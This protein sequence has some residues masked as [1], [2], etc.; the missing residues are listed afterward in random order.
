M[1][2]TD[3]TIGT[4]N[5]S[6]PDT[7]EGVKIERSAARRQT[8][9]GRGRD[10]GILGVLVVL[11]ITL[12]LTTT[13]FM[14][15]RNMTNV[16]EA[17]VVLGILA[18]SGGIVIIAGGLDLSAGAIY[19]TSAVVSVQISNVTNPVV[20]VVAGIA[21]GAALGAI[22]GIL[23]TVGRVSV[24]V[25]T[26]GT[27][28]VFIGFASVLSNSQLLTASDPSF[29]AWANTEILGVSSSAW[30]FII[31]AVALSVMLSYSVLGRNIRAT[32]GNAT[33][34][35]LSGVPT[36]RVLAITLILSG[37]CA[38]VAGTLVA[39]QSGL[40]SP[41]TSPTIVFTGLAAILIGG[42][43]VY[44]GIGS[45]WRTVVGV[46]VLTVISNGFNLLGVD[47]TYQ[48]VVTGILIVIAISVDAWSRK[49]S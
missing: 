44:G 11:V 7:G 16:L 13:T 36:Q 46:A 25:G 22:N 2:S 31:I 30:I 1:N 27:S 18:V 26:L 38:G 6:N 43:S 37:A 32:G 10:L 23:C 34:A 41:T 28:I 40:I 8:W 45:V 20:G 4:S 48:Q 9:M 3:T 49:R 47:P 21:A 14:T 12:S 19:V 42:N 29:T 33:A 15:V 39:S 17:A 5:E 35:R 24:F